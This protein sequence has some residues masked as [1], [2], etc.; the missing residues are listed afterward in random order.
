MSNGDQ[1]DGQ[2]HQKTRQPHAVEQQSGEDKGLHTGTV[3][4][5]L[6]ELRNVTLNYSKYHIIS[7]SIKIIKKTNFLKN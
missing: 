4:V 3:A 1:H 7:H 6:V 5:R 2:V